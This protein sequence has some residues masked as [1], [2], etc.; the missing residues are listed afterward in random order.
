MEDMFPLLFT[1]IIK[2]TKPQEYHRH[3]FLIVEKQQF[4][5][6]SFLPSHSL[7]FVFFFFLN[8]ETCQVMK[9]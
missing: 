9:K 7:P 5:F 4:F 8:P 2:G 3:W 1:E 6:F